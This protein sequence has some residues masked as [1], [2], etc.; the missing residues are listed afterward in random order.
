MNKHCIIRRSLLV[1]SLLNEPRFN[2]LLITSYDIKRTDNLA[3][4]L[5]LPKRTFNLF[6]GFL[7]CH[8][9]ASVLSES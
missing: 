3:V 5:V 2:F 9:R 6:H 8:M 1:A 7:A 4:A